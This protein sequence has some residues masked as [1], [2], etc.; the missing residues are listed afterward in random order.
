MA[1]DSLIDE[2]R[3]L[4]GEREALTQARAD[5]T[6]RLR[7]AVVALLESGQVSEVEAARLAHVNR[8]T[9][10]TWVGKQAWL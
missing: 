3:R 9:I 8:N 1:D 10:R 4:A 7:A 6:E 5:V 2:V